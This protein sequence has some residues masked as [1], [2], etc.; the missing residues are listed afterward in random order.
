MFFQPFLSGQTYN[1]RITEE[2]TKQSNQRN[3]ILS[4]RSPPHLHCKPFQKRKL[5]IKGK[6]KANLELY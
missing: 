2:R 4:F 5:A 6:E 3:T 1:M